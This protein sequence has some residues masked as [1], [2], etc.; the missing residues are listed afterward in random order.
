MKL[1]HLQFFVEIC[2]T[3]A[4]SKASE[5]LYISQQ[6]LSVIVKKLE[7]ELGYP[8]F[9]RHHSG[10]ILTEYG[11]LLKISAERILSQYEQCQA[12]M[13]ML[14]SK[15]DG[16][17]DLYE[18]SFVGTAFSQSISE[19]AKEHPK[20]HIHLHEASMDE[21]IKNFEQPKDGK[22]RA[23]FVSIP[24]FA[25]KTFQLRHPK[26]HFVTL[27]R[28]RFQVWVNMNSELARREAISLKE[29]NQ[30]PI[31]HYISPTGVSDLI[32]SILNSYGEPNIVFSS[33][34]I[35]MCLQAVS[36]GMGVM[37]MPDSTMHN[38]I[39]ST[40]Y[41]SFARIRLEEDMAFNNGLLLPVGYKP[42]PSMGN[43][44]QYMRENYD[45]EAND[46]CDG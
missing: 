16:E 14:A 12:N 28:D 11:E 3:G 37:L 21:I 43:F 44:L 38:P 8:L 25:M 45:T 9:R 13:R 30:C 26:L 35:A 46:R 2:K 6:K 40:V 29:F 39:F 19:Y 20:V 4:I 17:I 41:S 24:P 33:S 34:N 42:T 31:I 1:E 32:A 36:S 15:V 23:A 5:Q 22:D 18:L 27:K 10:V 7:E